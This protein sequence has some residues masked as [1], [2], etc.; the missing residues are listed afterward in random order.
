[1]A[2]GTAGV[3][4]GVVK[5]EEARGKGRGRERVVCKERRLREASRRALIWRSAVELAGRH[6]GEGCK[7][8][9]GDAMVSLAG[10]C[11]GVRGA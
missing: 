11:R 4:V 9:G 3:I 1:M 8:T 7:A 6:T 2:A 10:S 5:M